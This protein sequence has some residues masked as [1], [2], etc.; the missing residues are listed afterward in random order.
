MSKYEIHWETLNSTFRQGSTRRMRHI[1]DLMFSSTSRRRFKDVSAI[2][3]G[4]RK[5][6]L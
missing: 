5:F 1:E 2:E 6:D 4:L 3:E